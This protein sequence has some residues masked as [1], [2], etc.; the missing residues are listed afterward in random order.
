[1]LLSLSSS[2]NSVHGAV[3]IRNVVII[4]NT[5]IWLTAFCTIFQWIKCWWLGQKVV[6]GDYLVNVFT[7]V[8]QLVFRFLRIN[9]NTSQFIK[10]YSKGPQKRDFHIVANYCLINPLITNNKRILNMI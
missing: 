2:A 5:V 8:L 10:F 3:I 7:K 6:R 1:M 4:L 9:N